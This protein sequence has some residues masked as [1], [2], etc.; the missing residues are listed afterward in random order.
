MKEREIPYLIIEKNPQFISDGTSF[1]AG[2]AAD[3]RTLK[4]AWVEKAPAALITT[5]DDAINIYLTKYLRSLRPDIQIISRATL[6]R[7]VSTLYRAGADFVMSYASL[8]A[9][10]IYNFL[11]REET[12]LLAEGLN[13]FHQKS[14]P[15]LLGRSL[16]DSQ[17]REK[18]GCSVVGIRNPGGLVI[19]PDPHAPIEGSTEL[20]LIGTYEGERKFRQIFRV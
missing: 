19:N 15:S 11:E 3:I 12:L 7:N 9:N 10:A 16:A 2:D 8:G 5:H 13:I 18:T 17:I 20:I 4:K 6:D 1:V 14:P